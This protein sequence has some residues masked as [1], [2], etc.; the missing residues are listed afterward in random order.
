MKKWAK[1][2]NG[3]FS[4]EDIYMVIKHENNAQ[5]HYLLDKSISKLQWGI[6]SHQSEWPASKSLTLHLFIFRVENREYVN[7]FLWGL[8]QSENK[9][10]G[11]GGIVFSSDTKK[12]IIVLRNDYTI[13]TLAT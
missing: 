12:S 4:K 1:G 8:P 7:S 2:L 6:T 5:H 9:T 11:H 10:V 3:H 13:N